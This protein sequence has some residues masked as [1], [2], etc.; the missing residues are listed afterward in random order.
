MQAI[1]H[2]PIT[3]E[4]SRVLNISDSSGLAGQRQPHLLRLLIIEMSG[5]DT[6]YATVAALGEALGNDLGAA[7]AERF[8]ALSS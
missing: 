3:A 5:L 6:A 8:I 2:A 7:I 4:A 1:E